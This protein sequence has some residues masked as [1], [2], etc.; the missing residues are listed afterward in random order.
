MI[1]P[2]WSAAFLALFCV[3]TVLIPT[4]AE[5]KPGTEVIIKMDPYVVEGERVLPPPESWRYVL[6]PGLEL[7]RSKKVVMAPGY[8][9][10]SNLSEK[11][12]RLFV[13]ELQ[14]RQL[15][16]TLLWPMIVQALPR[17]PMV[18]ILDRTKQAWAAPAQSDALAWQGDPINAAAA[19]A[20]GFDSW[21]SQAG[22][23]IITSQ[24]GFGPDP[25]ADPSQQ[26]NALN[27]RLN[28]TSDDPNNP[29][30]NNPGTP[31]Q[32]PFIKRGLHP[33]PAG[34][35]R[36][37]ANNGIVA[38]QINADV[39]LAGVEDAPTEEQLAADLSRR[40]AE[41][42]LAS[43]TQ[44]PPL[45]FDSGLGWLIASA[46]V[47]PTRITFA[48][49]KGMLANQTAMPSLALLLTK[50]TAL[51][52]EEDLLAATF[53]HYG[54]YGNNNKNT[55]KFMTLVQRQSQGPVSPE[56]FKEIFGIS[57]EKMEIELATYGRT[58]AAYKSHEMRGDLPSLPPL[59]VGEA[60]QSETARLQ[61]DSLITQG[62]PDLALS[63][64]RIAYW[65]GEREPAMLAILAGLEEKQGSLERARK[66][67]Q[68]L[69]AL[70]TPPTRVFVVEAK[71]RF[72]DATATKQPQEKLTV[73]ETRA[74]MDPLGRAVQAGQVSEDNCEFFSQ[75][76]LRS[77]GHPHESIAAFLD[78]AAKKFPHNSTICE[79]ASFAKTK[80]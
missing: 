28:S 75:V 13:E 30:P 33:L 1:S 16:G 10:L 12:T 31:E 62:K 53:T 23:Q 29:T 73:A 2:K 36:V 56:Q 55:E 14:L 8:E 20:E 6:V 18:I 4:Q 65:R 47:T 41:F 69:M 78:R 37:R 21:A 24:Q 66:I 40:A 9:V 26:A 54:L 46:Q 17:Q 25:L 35:T 19:K 59:K 15:A 5:E 76:V 60:T 42:A 61:A 70:T 49:T 80:P 51:T 74:I 11:N 45:W 32:D 43:L 72:R 50:A 58:F 27:Q 63:V 71:L 57:I 79:A 77:N 48:D 7:T 64:L 52:Y 67:T 68:A 3:S 34:F 39:P 22:T 44:R 38:A